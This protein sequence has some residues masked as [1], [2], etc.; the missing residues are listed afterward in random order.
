MA[1]CRIVRELKNNR[2]K[3]TIF[4]AFL[5]FCLYAQSVTLLNYR[6]FRT[7]SIINTVVITSTWQPGHKLICHSRKEFAWQIFLSIYYFC[8][9]E[10]TRKSYLHHQ[11]HLNSHEL[12]QFEMDEESANQDPLWWIRWRTLS[13][14]GR[15]LAL[16]SESLQVTKIVSLWIWR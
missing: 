2:K 6:S 4:N 5:K 14:I 13:A 10:S 8:C 12:W 15:V 9:V 3:S 1:I 11:T 16:P 7:A